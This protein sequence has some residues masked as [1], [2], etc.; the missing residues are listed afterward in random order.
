MTLTFY[1][2]YGPYGVYMYRLDWV[3]LCYFPSRCPLRMYRRK[4]VNLLWL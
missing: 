2:E 4:R 1:Y 3:N